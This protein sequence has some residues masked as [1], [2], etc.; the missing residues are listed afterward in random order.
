LVLNA[1]GKIEILKKILE[2]QRACSAQTNRNGSLGN[3]VS[4]ATS[5]ILPLR[6]S[7]HACS[8]CIKAKRDPDKNKF[9]PD[10]FC[11]IPLV[12]FAMIT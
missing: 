6:G 12:A 7:L 5:I 4:C 9:S 2:V 1:R 3:C 11:F 8:R 10:L